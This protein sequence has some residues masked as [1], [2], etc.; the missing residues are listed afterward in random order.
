[1]VTIIFLLWGKLATSKRSVGGVLPLGCRLGP[2]GRGG[3]SVDVYGF[4]EDLGNLIV[5]NVLLSVTVFSILA[6][7]TL[8]QQLAQNFSATSL[9]HSAL[10][11]ADHEGCRFLLMLIMSKLLLW[12]HG[13]AATLKNLDVRWWR[14]AES[15]RTIIIIRNVEI[16]CMSS[17]LA[18]LSPTW[19]AIHKD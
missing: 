3:T 2:G 16:H 11:Q 12:D 18:C 1:M 19:R 8:Y 6:L 5:S 4:P 13:Y 10:S 17:F 15:L 9:S 7:L 14:R